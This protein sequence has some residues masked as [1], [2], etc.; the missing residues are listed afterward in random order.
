MLYLTMMQSQICQYHLISQIGLNEHF[1]LQ[2]VMQLSYSILEE[3]GIALS[4]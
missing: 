3:V 4:V 1:N 2:V